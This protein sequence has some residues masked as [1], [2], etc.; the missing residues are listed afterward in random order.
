MT[1]KHSRFKK[2]ANEARTSLVKE[3]RIKKRYVKGQDKITAKT[4]DHKWLEQIRNTENIELGKVH[5]L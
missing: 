1:A 2:L 3:P 5:V 4:P